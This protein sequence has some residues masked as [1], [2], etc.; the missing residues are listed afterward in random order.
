M[1]T[2]RSSYTR[3]PQI[4]P[5]PILILISLISWGRRK[6][7][8]ELMI[9]LQAIT[10]LFF[11]CHR[12][13]LKGGDQDRRTGNSFEAQCA[14]WTLVSI[15]GAEEEDERDCRQR[16]VKPHV[17]WLWSACSL[18]CF[19]CYIK[20]VYGLDMAL[21]LQPHL[22]THS[23]VLAAVIGRIL[24]LAFRCEYVHNVLLVWRQPCC[25]FIVANYHAYIKGRIC[26]NLMLICRIQLVLVFSCLDNV[27]H[28]VDTSDLI[29]N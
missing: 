9:L 26:A 29:N 23:S 5:L 25:L 12:Y 7:C 24:I 2:T 14:R 11:P 1:V 6:K 19:A 18:C 8:G 13:L 27:M 21:S 28:F 17:F 22:K 20:L 16:L 15:R 10:A 4:F 3:L